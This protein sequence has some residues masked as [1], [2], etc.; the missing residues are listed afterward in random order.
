MGEY[1]EDDVDDLLSGDDSDED[2]DND[3]GNQVN[4][5]R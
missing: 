4:L 2:G 5:L 1:Q 3:K